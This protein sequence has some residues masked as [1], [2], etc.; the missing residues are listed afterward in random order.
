LDWQD[1]DESPDAIREVYLQFYRC[2]W[3]SFSNFH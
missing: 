3:T 1:T 2:A